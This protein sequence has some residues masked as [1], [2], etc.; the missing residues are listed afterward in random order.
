MCLDWLVDEKQFSKLVAIMLLIWSSCRFGRTSCRISEGLQL[1]MYTH[2]HAYVLTN[3]HMHTCWEDRSAS[4]YK[5]HV[6]YRRSS[7]RVDNTLP[8]S[9]VRRR[10]ACIRMDMCMYTRIHVIRVTTMD[11]RVASCKARLSVYKRLCRHDLRGS[12]RFHF[13]HTKPFEHCCVCAFLNQTVWTLL[14]IVLMSGLGCMFAKCQHKQAP[15]F[16]TI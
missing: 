10:C 15:V 1:C 11:P 3:V 6:W 16:N 7:Q 14:G 4:H 9:S 12:P 13:S 2:I 8:T 5:A